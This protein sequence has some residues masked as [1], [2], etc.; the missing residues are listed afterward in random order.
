MS[1][2]LLLRVT[3]TLVVL[4]FGLLTFSALR[5]NPDAIGLTIWGTSPHLIALLFVLSAR[6]VRKVWAAMVAIVLFCV[7]GV[8]I[9]HSGGARG[10]FLPLWEMGLLAVASMVLSLA[11]RRVIQG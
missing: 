11:S 2:I 9:F 10:L 3:A 7:A 5:G 1:V 8:S 4:G 6:D